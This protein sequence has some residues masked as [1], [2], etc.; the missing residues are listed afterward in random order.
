M[1]DHSQ[2][3]TTT[4]ALERTI[5]SDGQI[6]HWFKFLIGLPQIESQV[7]ADAALR[8]TYTRYKQYE[9]FRY[10]IALLLVADVSTSILFEKYVYLWGIIFLMGFYVYAEKQLQRLTAAV[11]C[12]IIQCDFP[13]RSF[14]EK[15]LYQIGE[16]YQ[17]KYNMPSIIDALSAEDIITTYVILFYF[18]LIYVICPIFNLYESFILFALLFIFVKFCLTMRIVYRHLK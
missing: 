5:E 12:F 13:N 10:L 4:E 18:I 6:Y 11:G 2:K 9:W 14:E 15:T 3:V 8:K 7:L 16:F 17:Q 1:A